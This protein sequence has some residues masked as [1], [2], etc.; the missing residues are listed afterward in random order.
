MLLT[1]CVHKRESI[2]SDELLVDILPEAQKEVL[3]FSLK[4]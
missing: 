1:S 2:N 4:I 3:K